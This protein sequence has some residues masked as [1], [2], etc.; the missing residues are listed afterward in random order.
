[1]RS[2]VASTRH[3]ANNKPGPAVADLD[4]L[5]HRL[6]PSRSSTNVHVAGRERQYP[7]EIILS[8]SP[9]AATIASVPEAR[10]L[11]T[12]KKFNQPEFLPR[13]DGSDESRGLQP[14]K[15]RTVTIDFQN[16]VRHPEISVLLPSGQL[17][18]SRRIAY[19]TKTNPRRNREGSSPPLY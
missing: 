2:P 6:S 15:F 8:M 1:M 4:P 16:P 14:F 7:E 18:T 3:T 12:F 9:M 5:S 11:K 17:R 10:P 19:N 13:A